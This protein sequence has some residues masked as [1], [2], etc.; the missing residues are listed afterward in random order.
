MT[1]GEAF[2]SYMVIPPQQ[3]SWLTKGYCPKECY[4]VT[5]S[6]IFC[7]LRFGNCLCAGISHRKK[8]VQTPGNVM[9]KCVP[10][11][12]HFI[13]FHPFSENVGI[14]NTS[15]KRDKGLCFFPSHS[16]TGLVHYW[17]LLKTISYSSYFQIQ[18]TY[19]L[20]RTHCCLRQHAVQLI[21]SNQSIDFFIE[22]RFIKVILLYFSI[23]ACNMDETCPQRSWIT[24]NCPWWQLWF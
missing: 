8:F 7:S 12:S 3:E 9:H 6:Q 21:M 18:N 13:Y 11:F 14:D 17:C 23:R 16:S 20:E 1:V 19:K 5:L 22:R 2:T 24:W 15:R 4:Q 10:T